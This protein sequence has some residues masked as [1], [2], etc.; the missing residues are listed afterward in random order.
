MSAIAAV[1]EIVLPLLPTANSIRSDV[2]DAPDMVAIFKRSRPHPNCLATHVIRTTR[3]VHGTFEMKF[4]QRNANSWSRFT[5][6]SSAIL[7]NTLTKLS[8]EDVWLISR[9]CV[10]TAVNVRFAP[11]TTVMDGAIWLSRVSIATARRAM[12]LIH[13]FARRRLRRSP[14]LVVPL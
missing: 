14:Q 4:R 9:R 1:Y 10:P 7:I 5:A 6:G 8:K 11:T 13:P 3:P 2:R 12:R